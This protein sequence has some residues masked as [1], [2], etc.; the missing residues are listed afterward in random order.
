MG[1]GFV[2]LVW[3]FVTTL[4]R[5]WEHGVLL[6][7]GAVVLKCCLNPALE[8]GMSFQQF[9]ILNLGRNLQYQVRA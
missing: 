6:P 2:L 7:F 1:R 4:T 5:V 9:F 3:L 8:G